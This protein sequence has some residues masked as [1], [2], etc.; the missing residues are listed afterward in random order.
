MSETYYPCHDEH[1]ILDC[2]FSPVVNS[3]Y[4]HLPH[5]VVTC[6]ISSSEQ[7]SS[8]ETLAPDQSIFSSES[9]GPMGSGFP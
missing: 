3:E 1:Y 2:G 9:I 7:L 6:P 5:K 8:S 4:Q